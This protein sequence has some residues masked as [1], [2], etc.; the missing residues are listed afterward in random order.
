MNGLAEVEPRRI[1]RLEKSNSHWNA[2]YKKASVKDAD[3]DGDY[4]TGMFLL[5][6]R[7]EKG[8]S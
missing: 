1:Y 4:A 5:A 2:N 6:A 7:R 3:G 8:N